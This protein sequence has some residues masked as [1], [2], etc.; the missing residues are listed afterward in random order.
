MAVT[1]E[2]TQKMW[3]NRKEHHS[4]FWRWIAFSVGIGWVPVILTWL[5]AALEKKPISISEIITHGELL[6]VSIAIVAEALRDLHYANRG[7][8][9][10]FKTWVLLGAMIV[11]IGSCFSFGTIAIHDA[12]V[13][14]STAV[15]TAI[16]PKKDIMVNT[17]QLVTDL[18]DLK[19]QED[20]LD[21]GL[22]IVVSLIIF[23]MAVATGG[24]CK[25]TEKPVLEEGEASE[26]NFSETTETPKEVS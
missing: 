9:D 11:L 22:I 10:N 3:I 25:W 4:S 26:A 1:K 23:V 17:N 21:T 8:S 19:N 6:I 15:L 7:S 13:T 18:S 16:P 20:S 12:S 5:G 14:S 24:C 2:T